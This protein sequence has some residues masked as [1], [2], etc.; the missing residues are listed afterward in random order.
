MCLS[1]ECEINVLNQCNGAV[2]IEM[3]FSRESHE[4]GCS[5][6]YFFSIRDE[7]E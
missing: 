6:L 7:S 4:S 3:T 1:Y 2:E 5:T